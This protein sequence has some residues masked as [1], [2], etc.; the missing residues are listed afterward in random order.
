[1]LF[2]KLLRI[3][4]ITQLPDAETLFNKLFDRY[5]SYASINRDKLK[6]TF[7]RIYNNPAKAKYC[8][9]MIRDVKHLQD[10]IDFRQA[11]ARRNKEMQG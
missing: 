2:K 6:K 10:W 8:S 11:G 9:E 3:N 5:I 1:M 4:H 7:H